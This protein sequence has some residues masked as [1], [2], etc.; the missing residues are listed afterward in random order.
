[1]DVQG[2]LLSSVLHPSDVLY[3]GCILCYDASSCLALLYNELPL[4]S[5]VELWLG[6]LAPTLRNNPKPFECPWGVCKSKFCSMP[7]YV[8]HLRA[9]HLPPPKTFQ[10]KTAEQLRR[11]RLNHCQLLNV[12]HGICLLRSLT[13]TQRPYRRN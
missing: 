3:Y 6:I 1:M 8:D 7:L 11:E 10:W 13:C 9:N 5:V 2:S 12:P 4:T